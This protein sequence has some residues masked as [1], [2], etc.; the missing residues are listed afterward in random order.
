MPV[1]QGVSL[2][3]AIMNQTYLRVEA[4]LRDVIPVCQEITVYLVK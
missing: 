4:V 2:K 3:L 1:L